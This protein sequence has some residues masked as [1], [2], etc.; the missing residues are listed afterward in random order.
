MRYQ[1]DANEFLA[2]TLPL[3]E[4]ASSTQLA[5]AVK[6]RWRSQE[7]CSLLKH[8][9]PEVRTTAT[10]VIGLIGDM[11]CAAGIAHLLHDES[12]RV[13][14]VAEHAL[15]S[16]WC[17]AGN[18][19]ASAPFRKGVLA[20]KQE[21]FEQAS[22]HFH[23]AAKRDPEFIEAYNQCA[24]SHYCLGEYEQ[25]IEDARRVV[26]IIP[27]H[28]GAICTMGH[29]YVQMDDLHKALRCYRRGLQINPHLQAIARTVSQLAYRLEDQRDASGE[30]HFS[31]V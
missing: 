27:Y 14:E 31:T 13:N 24:I 5:Q 18:D 30:Y 2:V 3:L 25:A 26:R 19:E 10:L 23:E 4:S 22:V 15:M 6:V 16:I 29:C 20:I 11:H 12:P 7:V 21:A 8:R 28:F 17:R 1:M 9:D